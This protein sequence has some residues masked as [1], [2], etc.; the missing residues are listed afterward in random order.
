[1]VEAIA[2]SAEDYL[3]D[4]LNFKLSPGATYVIDRKSVT[5]FTSGSQNYVSGQ[6]ARVIRIQMNSDG[7]V[8][9]SNSLSLVESML[10][11]EPA[12]WV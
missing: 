8:E 11:H 4:G 12:V 3:I 7:W 1:M 9:C 6:G 5:W 10:Q 2:N